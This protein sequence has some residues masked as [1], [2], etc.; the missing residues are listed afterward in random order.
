MVD[1]LRY[2]MMPLPVAHIVDAQLAAKDTNDAEP[3]SSCEP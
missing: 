1:D 2:D 3:F